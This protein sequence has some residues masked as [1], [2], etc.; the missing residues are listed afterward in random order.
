[1]QSFSVKFHEQFAYVNFDMPNEKVNKFNQESMAELSS[2]ID[3]LEKRTGLDWVL[4]DSNKPGIFIAG[5]DIN[6]LNNIK[7][8]AEG[9][10]L[11]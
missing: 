5:A 2:I 8:V 9:E 7:T 10:A 11:I 4:F 1:M 3:Q 6:E